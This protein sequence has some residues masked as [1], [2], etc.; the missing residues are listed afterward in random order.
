[1]LLHIVADFGHADLAFAEVSQQIKLLLPEAELILTSIPPFATLAAGFCVAQLGLNKAPENTLIFHNVAPRRDD[2]KARQNNDGERLAYTLLPNGVKVVGVHAGYA[3]SFLRDCAIELR[4]VDVASAGSQF[5]SR[6]IFP[7]GVAAVARQK[8]NAWAEAMPRE[9]IP[10]IPE[11]RVAYIDGF[12]NIKTT[13]AAGQYKA[14]QALEVTLNNIRQTAIV[15]DGSFSV[16][17]GTLTFSPGSSG[18]SIPS[19][20]VR[21]MELFLRGGS[22]AQLFGQPNNAEVIELSRS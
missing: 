16:P 22:A 9:H 10:A 4:Y 14:G 12:G 11:G 13:F 1:M 7:A 3:F 21:W 8:S 15:S 5:R 19:G 20:Q 17:Q 2:Q 6:D 18:W